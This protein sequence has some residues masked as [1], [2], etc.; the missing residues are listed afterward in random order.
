MGETPRYPGTYIEEVPSGVRTITGVATSITAFI[1]RTYRGPVN[2]PVRLR[3][4]DDFARTFGGLWTHSTVG[5]AVQHYFLN[6]GSDAIIVRVHN[7]ATAATIDLEASDDMLILGATAEGRWGN[8]LRATVAH[9]IEDRLDDSHF[10]LTVVERPHGVENP[11]SIEVF[12]NVSVNPGSQRFVTRVLEMESLLVRVDGDVPDDRPDAVE[13]KVA[14][15][16]GTD[17]DPIEDAQ[18]SDP[19][20]TDSKEGLWALEKAHHFNI[21]CIPPPGRGDDVG[22]ITSDAA[23]RFCCIH[24]AMYV[25]DTQ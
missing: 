14:N 1:G 4:F 20:L 17:G 10:T 7:G 23:A 12:R 16:D 6:G 2:D 24:R 3:S 5:Y 13:D 11:I 25:M 19:D 18:I 15:T 21:L 22:K 9:D 8:D